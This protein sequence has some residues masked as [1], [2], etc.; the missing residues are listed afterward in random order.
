[1]SELKIDCINL[2]IYGMNSYIVSADDEAMIIDI[3][4]LS[5][6]YE[7]YDKLL[8]G[9]K[10]K[11][12]IYT[13][14]HFD[15]ISGSDD[16]RKKYKGV[17][18][19][20]HSLDYDFFGDATLNASGYFGNGIKWQS[21][22]IKFEDGETFKLKDIEFKVIH[23][24][25]HTRGG[26]CYYTEGHLFCGDTIFANGIGR[27]D[28]P[29]GNYSELENSIMEKLFKLDDET[30]LYPGHEAYGFKLGQRKR[31]GIFG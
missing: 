7:D 14:G 31:I 11:R 16:I 30:L 21:P 26:V 28:L 1:M 8:D 10:L 27:T 25:G 15:H 9:K 18:H 3:S 24:P 19:C 13:H 29:T 6:G 22:E 20:I 5:F 23:T 12:V 2:N 17:E 4:K